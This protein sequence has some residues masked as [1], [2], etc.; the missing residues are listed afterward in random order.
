MK[1]KG[2]LNAKGIEEA[3]GA[4]YTELERAGVEEKQCLAFRLTLEEILN[5]YLDESCEGSELSV[6]CRKLFGDFEIVIRLNC[7]EINPFERENLI[8]GRLLKNFVIPPEW[9]AEKGTNKLRFVFTLYNTTVKNYIFTWKYIKKQKG[10]LLFSIF[11]Q[12]FSVLFGILA[13]IVSAGIIQAY[14]NDKAYMVLEIAA[15]LLIVSLLKNLFM[16]IS[17]QGYN[18]VYTGALSDLE[19]DVVDGVLRITTGCIEEK[20][21]GLFIQR[22]TGDTSRIASGYNSIADMLVNILN[23][24][25][26]LIAMFSIDHSIALVTVIIVAVQVFVELFRTKRLFKDDRVF[27]SYNEQYTGL[28]GEMVRGHRDIRLLNNE[29]TFWNELTKRI[30]TAN[31]KRLYMQKRSW[32]LKLFRWETG[33]FGTFA[34]I[35]LLSYLIAKG[36]MIPATALIIY[37]YYSDLS[38]SSLKTIGSFLDS[39]TDFNIS[40][41]RVC[42]LLTS[43]EFPKEHF[44]NE[45]LEKARGEITFEHV[46]FSYDT[47]GKPG[48]GRKILQD[49]SFVI[50]PG[51]TVGLVGKSGCG[52]TTTF[53]LITK[54]YESA[55]GKVLLD[56]KNIRDLT[57][58]SI[59]DNITVVSQNPY[60][61][62]M[63][64]RDNLKLVKP[65]LTD[66]E[67]ENVCRL[68]C[69][70]ED[71]KLLPEGYDTMIG[72]GGVNLSGGQRQRLAIA[73]S[74]L[75]DSAIVLFDEA[76]SALDNDTQARIQQAIDNMRKDRTVIIIA[77][78][79][80]TVINSDRIFFMQDGSILA[81][82]SHEKLLETCEP[83]RNLAMMDAAGEN[84][85]PV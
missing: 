20:G 30:R 33:E 18:H 72:E 5:V 79:L 46:D 64:V 68:A 28:V 56:G 26:I 78:R 32:N 85:V 15:A 38:S 1:W 60:I 12:L 52:K 36:V 62:K 6:R 29:K 22:I 61:F 76:T 59:R 80:S 75:R 16:V 44:G 9:S 34:F 17:N 53:N 11:A 14:A 71:I 7:R 48:E 63:T 25:G 42:A 27:R 70:D 4:A 58:D 74:M 21:T 77:H 49:M 65:D 67:M 13:P 66:E 43:A 82:G 24:A 57:K 35:V 23:Y 8:L 19:S 2:I 40:N 81:Q 51:E 31:E 83:Y 3:S 55:A 45:V 69:I 41:E 39:I 47:A 84:V 10:L 37:N 73:R 50:K 54:L